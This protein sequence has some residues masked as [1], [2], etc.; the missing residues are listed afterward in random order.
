MEETFEWKGKLIKMINGIKKE[1]I[2][3]RIREEI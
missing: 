2:Y 3:W 1:R